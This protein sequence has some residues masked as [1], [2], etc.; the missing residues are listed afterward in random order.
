MGELSAKRAPR[1]PVSES[2]HYKTALFVTNEHRL[3]T[4]YQLHIKAY[5]VSRY[6]P[7]PTSV[8]CHNAVCCQKNTS[9]VTRK[10]KIKSVFSLRLGFGFSSSDAVFQIRSLGKSTLSILNSM[11]DS[12]ISP[13]NI[14]MEN[15][16]LKVAHLFNLRVVRLTLCEIS[17]VLQAF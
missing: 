3:L 6:R 13:P 2:I 14:S 11:N 10:K 5:L 17:L 8:D 1:F 9:F 4:G 15:E 16:L 7:N 12:T